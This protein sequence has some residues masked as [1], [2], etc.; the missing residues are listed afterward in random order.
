MHNKRCCLPLKKILGESQTWPASVT[1]VEFQRKS[2]GYLLITSVQEFLANA[3]WTVWADCSQ[4]KMRSSSVHQWLT[5]FPQQ[6]VEHE[7]TY[8]LG[9]L[10][11]WH[12]ISIYPSGEGDP[13]LVLYHSHSY[14][15]KVIKERFSCLKVLKS[16][17]T[18]FS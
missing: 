2:L 7:G 13:F 18:R 14:V 4:S 6:E 15:S 17:G 12:V 5:G 8:V 11:E 3:G 10:A 9:M 1:T 16:N